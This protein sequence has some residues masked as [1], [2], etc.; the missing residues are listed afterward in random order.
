MELLFQTILE[1]D[2]IHKLLFACCFEIIIFCHTLKPAFLWIFDVM[3]VH[4][5]HFYKVIE[6][7]IRTEK[8]LPSEVVRHLATVL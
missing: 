8:A 2:L 3:D 5:F 4:A 7:V 1:Q 6:L